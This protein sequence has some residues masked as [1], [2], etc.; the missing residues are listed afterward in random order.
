MDIVDSKH[1]A[2][3][4]DV[5]QGLTF[6]WFEKRTV[7]LDGIKMNLLTQLGQL[8]QFFGSNNRKTRN[9]KNFEQL[10]DELKDLKRLVE[11]QN[12]IAREDSHKDLNK[13]FKALRKGFINRLLQRE[14]TQFL[15]STIDLYI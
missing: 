1:I 8:N 12:Q 10:E 15:F 2:N 7:I 11:R 9:I 13:I 5:P 6:N 4:E 14:S 3:L